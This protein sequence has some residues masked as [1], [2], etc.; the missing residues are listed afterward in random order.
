M[1][2][3]P[4]AGNRTLVNPLNSALRSRR[5]AA[6]ESAVITQRP[7]AGDSVIL[8]RE[9]LAQSKPKPAQNTP[10]VAQSSKP[11]AT[12]PALSASPPSQP[13]APRSFGQTDLDMIRDHFG[14]KQGDKNFNAEAD[15]DGNGTIDFRDMTHVLSHWGQTKP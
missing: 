3:N 13:S 7:N 9:A 5:A 4:L 2:T 12:T 6:A 11:A 1:Q 14:A 8:S 10:V 15:A